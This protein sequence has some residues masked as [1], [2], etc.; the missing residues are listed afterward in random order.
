MN[1][2]RSVAKR[3]GVSIAAVALVASM[4]LIPALSVSARVVNLTGELTT[5]TLASFEVANSGEA[6][7]VLM[8]FTLEPGASIRAH[9]HSGP[10]VLTVIA[11]TLQ[12]DLIRGE[13]TVNRDGVE[14]SA[15]IGDPNY[16][17]DGDSISYSPKAGTTLANFGSEPL[18]LVAT[19]LLN[20][21]EP[22]FDYDYWPPPSR[23]HLQ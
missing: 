1:P 23:P 14:K 16:L 18:T 19:L 4:T 3:I 20:P 22:V 7:L 10:A 17:Y 8:R 11:G 9:S 13:A 6:R 2:T 12:S 15:L 21:N 5:E